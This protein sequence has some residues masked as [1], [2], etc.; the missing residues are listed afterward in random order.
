LIRSFFIT[1]VS[2]YGTLALVSF[3]PAYANQDGCA[4]GKNSVVIDWSTDPDNKA[5]YVAIVVAMHSGAKVGFGT[6]GCATNYSS[7]PRSYRVDVPP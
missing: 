4:Y 6:D 2:T 7:A 5:M 1:S 3:W